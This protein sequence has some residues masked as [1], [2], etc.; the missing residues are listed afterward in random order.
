MHVTFGWDVLDNTD[1]PTGEVLPALT[2]SNIS[3][4]GR[5][6]SEITSGGGGSAGAVRRTATLPLAGPTSIN[7]LARRFRPWSKILLPDGN[8]ATFYRGVFVSTLPPISDDGIVVTRTLDLAGKEHR[9]SLD[10]LRAP[11]YVPTGTDALQFVRNELASR[12]GEATFDFPAGTALIE[13]GLA[14]EP[15]TNRLEY[16]NVILGA[17]GLGPLHCNDYGVPRV[18]FADDTNSK[19]AEHTYAPGTTQLVGGNLEALYPELPN[20]VEV[21]SNQAPTLVTEGNGK[22]T[23]RNQST[24]P[25][26]IDARTFE[27]FQRIQVD[28]PV[29]PATGNGQAA[30]EAKANGIAQALFAGGGY[31]TSGGVGYNPLHS[32]DDVVVYIKPRLGLV[33]GAEWLVA[34]WNETFDASHGITELDLEY[35]VSIT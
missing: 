20:V 12:Y 26:S 35:R 10:E 14:F 28:T 15:T 31:R 6:Q 23:L 33:S 17:A 19:P 22:I 7:L 2:G 30:L 1:T 5:V 34:S 27:V 16:Y 25:A 11:A 32:D 4:Q 29:D 8:S 3:W 24:G 21:L 9:Y 13:S 18:R